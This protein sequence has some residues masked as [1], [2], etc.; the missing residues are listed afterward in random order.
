MLEKAEIERRAHL[1]ATEYDG[2]Q[3]TYLAFYVEAVFYAAE[4]AEAAFR[5]F[6]M[7]VE[8][9][10]PPTEIVATVH[11]A[12]GHAAALSRFFFPV[13]K[14]ALPRARAARL[15]QIFTV[16]NGSALRDR[17][18]RNA[19][20]HFDERLDE[21]LLGDI[22]GC[23]FPGPI[24]DD[25]NLADDRMGHIFRLADPRNQAFVLLGQK[26]FF[27]EIRLEVERIVTQARLMR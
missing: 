8:A 13:G 11:E 12:L 4:R 3:P 2:I 18:L 7:C 27:G 6:T 16:S 1:V 24:V 23:I 9:D 22:V 20:E 5:R 26:H 19:L 14:R 25:A 17:D 10:D 21:Y 15:R